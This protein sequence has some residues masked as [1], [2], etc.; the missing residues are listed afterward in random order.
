MQKLL[1][2]VDGERDI[3]VISYD[4]LANLDQK[5][6]EAKHTSHQQTKIISMRVG[7]KS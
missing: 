4:I 1:V 2:E 5:R 3:Q 6:N 7:G